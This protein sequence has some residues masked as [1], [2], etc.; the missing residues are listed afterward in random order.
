MIAYMISATSL[1]VV[2]NGQSFIIQKDTKEFNDAL[3]A[4][5]NEDEE[6]LLEIKSIVDK[7]KKY[8]SGNISIEN[9]KVFFNGNELHGYVV[10][11][12]IEFY[13]NDYPWEALKN[14]IIK[15]YRNPSKVSI[16]MAYQFLETQRFN[17]LPDGNVIG[18]KGVNPDG[19]SITGNTNV[20]VL[21]G[22]V[23]SRGRILNEDNAV[24]EIP[25]N[26]VTDDPN[27]A[28]EQGLHIGSYAF[29]KSFAERGIVKLVKFSPED[30]VSVPNDSNHEKLRVCKYQVIE[31]MKDEGLLNSGYHNPISYDEDEDEDN[32]DDYED[33]DDENNY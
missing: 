1:S 2:V 17:I 29:A 12:L 18:F 3:E 19:Y 27:I 10:D 28:C 16:D 6:T 30:I 33:E 31:T 22:K 15:L 8:S 32:Y 24:I 25:R 7:I 5:R 11:R 20:Q 13:K 26:Q 9:N 23:D 21:S 4:I 14:F